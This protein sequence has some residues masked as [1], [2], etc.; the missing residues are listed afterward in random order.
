MSNVAWYLIFILPCVVE[1]DDSHDFD[2]CQQY[3]GGNV[4][5]QKQQTTAEDGVV[6][7]K[8]DF[9]VLGFMLT[10]IPHVFKVLRET[11]KNS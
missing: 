6:I 5:R 1:S 10:L 3:Y 9:H 4:K 2:R 11:V 8:R 7:A